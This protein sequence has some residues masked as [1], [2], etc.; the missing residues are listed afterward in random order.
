M[1]TVVLLASMLVLG[2]SLGVI[3]AGCGDSAVSLGPPPQ[4]T[5]TG[6]EVTTTLPGKSSFEVWF[7]SGERLVRAQRTHRPTRAVATAVNALLAG[8]TR[9]EQASGITTAIPL[10]TRLLG[11]SI[12]T[13]VASVDLTSDFESGGG[14][15]NLVVSRGRR[16]S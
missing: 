15:V 7:A 12:H 8:P 9:V 5:V 6:P 16:P 4:Q 10:G 14:K 11:I 13:G 2:A 3:L 1:R